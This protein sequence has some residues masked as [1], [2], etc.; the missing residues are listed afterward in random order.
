[1]R[2]FLIPLVAGLLLL[3]WLLRGFDAAAPI[4]E[5]DRDRS[6]RYQ[7]HDAEW[8]R[9]NADGELEM[10]VQATSIRYFDDQSAELDTLQ[11]DRLAG[12]DVWQLSA[13]GGAMPAYQQR[14]RLDAP[15]L[16][17][18]TLASDETLQLQAGRLW[19]DLPARTLSSDDALRLN[20]P[21]RSAQANGL[22]ADWAGRR[23]QL[24]GNVEVQ[25]AP[26]G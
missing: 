16:G 14:L 20:G 23:I 12:G 10:R 13:P 21:L 8:R 6:P 18:A 25:H 2:G 7:V 24:F 9:Y 5:A 17:S 1:M 3:W 19:L 26:P 22:L 11:L 15:V 4:R